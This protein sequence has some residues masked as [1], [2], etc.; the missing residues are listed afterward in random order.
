VHDLGTYSQAELAEIFG[1]GRSTV[2]RTVLRLRPP[3]A[4]AERPFAEH[5]DE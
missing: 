1:V 4:E 2:H 3:P 5:L